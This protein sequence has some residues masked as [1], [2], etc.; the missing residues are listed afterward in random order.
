MKYVLTVNHGT[1][2]HYR[3]LISDASARVMKLVSRDLDRRKL[4]KPEVMSQA[5]V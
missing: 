2:A 5:A 1:T 3:A 4:P